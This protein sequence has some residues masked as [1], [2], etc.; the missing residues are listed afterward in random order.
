[1]LNDNIENS[2][3]LYRRVI[4]NPSYWDVENGRGRPTSAVFKDSFGMSV[5]RCANFYQKKEL[6]KPGP[7]TLSAFEIF[8]KLLNKSCQFVEDDK[9]V[10]DEETLV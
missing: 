5:D 8:K 6:Y 3:Y 2:E 1:M 4:S 10:L 7:P 9:L